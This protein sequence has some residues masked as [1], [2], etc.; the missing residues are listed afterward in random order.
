MKRFLSFLSALPFLMFPGSAFAAASSC[1][2][3]SIFSPC[4]PQD[5]GIQWLEWL[6]LAKPINDGSGFS[7][8]LTQVTV[9]QK[10]IAG[11]LGFYSTG[12]LAI[13]GVILLVHLLYMVAETAHTGK[14]MGKANQI[15]APIRLVVAIGLLVPISGG[16]NTGQYIVLQ[17]GK[18]GSGLA[19]QTWN[20]FLTQ[21]A[22]ETV[23]S[24]PTTPPPLVQKA[25]LDLVT[26][27]AC[28][29]LYNF[30]VNARDVPDFSPMFSQLN[31]VSQSMSGNTGSFGN[32]IEGSVCGTYVVPQTTTGTAQQIALVEGVYNANQTAFVNFMQNQQVKDIAKKILYYVDKQNNPNPPT[33]DDLNTVVSL[34]YTPLANA[35]NGVANNQNTINTTIQQIATQWQNDGWVSAGAWF[36]TIAHVQSSVLDAYQDRAAYH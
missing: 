3:G 9:L 2:N 1:G 34:Y 26:M 27:M 12:A 10:A 21:L 16:L 31:T 14:P 15:W 17:V 30:E 18:W 29:N 19:S 6:F 36:N 33:P 23:P 5:Q 28:M 4:G 8:A 24:M 35:L 7:T 20:I 22:N 13:A 25:A 32:T 11:A